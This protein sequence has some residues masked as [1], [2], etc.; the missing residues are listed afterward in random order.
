MSA[1]LPLPT[2][3]NWRQPAQVRT[4]FLNIESILPLAEIAH[5]PQRI[6]PLPPAS[7]PLQPPVLP[8]AQGAMAWD[9]FLDETATDGIAV[10]HQGKL[11]HEW[12]SEAMGP[13]TRHIAMSATKSAVGLLAGAMAAHGG[14]DLAQ[15]VAQLVP[16]VKHTPYAD[17]TL[18]Q[19]LDMRAQPGLTPAELKAYGAAT[20]W[21]PAPEGA[22]AGLHAFYEAL[23]QRSGAH[24]G[25]FRYISANTDLL[26]WALERA[27]GVPLAQALSQFVW[28]PAGAAQP[29]A[30]TLDRQGAARGT[31]GLVLTL[32]DFARLGQAVIAPTDPALGFVPQWLDDVLTAGDPAAWDEGDFG[33][34]FGRPMHYRS[35]WYVVRGERPYAFAMGI[36]GQHLFVDPALQLVM[37]KLSSQAQPQEPQAIGW[38]LRAFEALRREFAG[39]G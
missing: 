37:A 39:G 18:R 5:D 24:G 3:A 26:G 12:R 25:P 16:E 4:S 30:I 23:P 15:A 35:G 33:R 7:T 28:Q 2:L 20:G 17:A 32:Q 38:T 1:P 19:L 22:P 31:G 36:H 6:A 29:A 14:L 13:H 21:D 9:R 10:L 8:A 34:G 11:V 27:A